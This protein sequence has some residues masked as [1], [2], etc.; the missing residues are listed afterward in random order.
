[1]EAGTD[2]RTMM[3]EWHRIAE[4]VEAQDGPDAAL[5]GRMRDLTAAITE[6]VPSEPAEVREWAAFALCELNRRIERALD[7]AHHIEV[8]L[9]GALGPAGDAGEGPCRVE[10]T[11]AGGR[12]VLLRIRRGGAVLA[13]AALDPAEATALAHALAGAARGGRAGEVEKEERR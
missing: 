2:L 13:E 5:V 11:T 1:M 10:L 3:A 9:P 8:T 6:G 12:G 7:L 4:R